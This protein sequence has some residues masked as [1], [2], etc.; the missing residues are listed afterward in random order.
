MREI[1]DR[2]CSALADCWDVEALYA[3]WEE[4]EK[5]FALVCQQ[6]RQELWLGSS[7]NL[8]SAKEVKNLLDQVMHWEERIHSLYTYAHLRHDE[9]LAKEKAQKSYSEIL[10]V[11]HV[12]KEAISWV[13]PSLLQ[14]SEEVWSQLV[15]YSGLEGYREYLRKIRRMKPYTR[16]SAEERIMAL[17]AKG[18]GSCGRAFGL[19][20]NA[21]L[22]FPDCHSRDKG[23]LPLTHGTYHVYMKDQDRDLR[24]QAFFHMHETFKQYENTV[25][26]LVQGEIESHIF[27]QKA[28]GFRSCLEASLYPHEIEVDVYF[29]LL[30]TVKKHRGILHEY[31]GLRKKAMGYSSLHVYDLSVPLVKE[32][33][34]KISYEEAVEAIVE[35]VACLGAS[36]QDIL[37]QGLQEGRWVD[38]YE[39]HKK[40]SGAYS[41]GCYRSKPYILMN[42]QGTLSDAMTLAHEAGHSMHTY[43][44]AKN[45]AYQ[46]YQYPIFLAEVAST[47]HEELLFA[48]L[49][50]KCKGKEE[51]GYLLQQK[52]DGIRSTLF[53]QVL[54]A[55]FELAIHV[56]ME[57]G[58]ALTPAILHA[59]YKE[60]TQEYFGKE[61]VIDEVASYEW[62]RIPHFYYN[63]YVYQY[64]TGISAAHVLA[65]NVL[66]QKEGAAERYL[67]FIAAGGSANPL[68]V[69]AKAGADMRSAGPVESTLLWFQDM[70]Q[71]WQ[72][73]ILSATDQRKS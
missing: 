44:S 35:S 8:S 63:F 34:P 6:T 70:L 56:W 9:D 54:F 7:W 4:W 47:F 42:Y 12:F 50:R 61:L 28:R 53:R 37:R 36:Y 38:R 30:E 58:K 18:L 5:E 1:K 71:E 31:V 3:G 62:A 73:I 22:R 49:L 41:S 66:Q 60:L 15:S 32:D 13:E 72:D 17:A 14:Q 52:V 27:L 65:Q 16:S 59:K 33:P 20:N 68:D 48:Y 64:A 23:A 39:N 69:L 51:R 46:D 29:Q 67:Q 19:L 2:E 57:E 11:W 26:A 10:H 55:E 45:Q 21:D 25:C 24:K 40:R 43:F